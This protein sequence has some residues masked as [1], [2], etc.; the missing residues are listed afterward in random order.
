MAVST[1]SSMNDLYNQIFEDA[2]FIARE[3][4]IMTNLVTNYSARGWM[5]RTL[6]TYP[7]LS[8]ETVAEGVDYAGATDW[9]KTSVGT[10]TPAQ[11]INQVILTDQR[12]ETDP[13][14]AMRDAATEMGNA[15]ATKIDTDLVT[16]MASLATDVG[17]GAGQSATIAKF[18]VGVSV[19]RNAKAMNPIYIVAHPYHWHDVWVALGQ[20][21]ANQ[22]LLGDVANQALRDFY[23]G[24][25]INV[26]WFVNANISVD[27]SD[28]AVSGIFNPQALAFDSRQ[29]PTMEPERDASLRATELNMTAGYAHGLGPRPTFGVK[30]TA[31]AATPS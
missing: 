25:W 28:D 3:N 13:Q 15:I 21:A 1:V 5:T 18:A 20:P 24:R 10:L 27:G 11:I 23:V 22:A 12:M 2:I 8:A 31:D 4:N 19:L 29:A 7:G 16:D 14:N 9:T 17:P 26:L 30:Y 6:A